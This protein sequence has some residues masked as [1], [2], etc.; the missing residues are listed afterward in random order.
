AGGELAQLVKDAT[1][2]GDGGV[3]AP[4]V[5]LLVGGRIADLSGVLE[6]EALLA[7]ARAELRPRGAG[8]RVVA[9]V[10]SRS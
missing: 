5:R 3:R 2:Y 4:A 10:E 1:A 7:L 6:P 8:E 9:V